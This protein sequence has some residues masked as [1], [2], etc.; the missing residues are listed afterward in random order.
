MVQ[1]FPTKP[2]DNPPV[3]YENFQTYNKGERM[4]TC[5]N[6]HLFPHHLDSTIIIL[7]YLSYHIISLPP[8][9]HLVFLM[10]FKEI[11]DI[12]TLLFK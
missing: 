5:Y 9:I 10:H 7:L 6:E 1:N 12:R 2:S 4:N 3:Y 8:T 11:S